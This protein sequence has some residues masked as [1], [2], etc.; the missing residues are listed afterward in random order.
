MI[1]KIS[2]K[3]KSISEEFLMITQLVAFSLS[4][5]LTEGLTANRKV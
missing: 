1:D 2:T 3:K 4:P 5:T